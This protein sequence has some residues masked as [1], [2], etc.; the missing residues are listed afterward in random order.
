MRH[1][2]KNKKFNRTR[3]QRKAL[4]NGL[5]ANLILNE[6]IKT[7]ETKAKSLRPFV[8]KLITK[9][10]FAKDLE[11][12]ENPKNDVAAIRNLT[13][14][15]PQKAHSKLINEVA[16]RYRQRN[17]GYTRIIKL[18]PRKTDGAEIAIIELVK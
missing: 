5:A 13:K 1:H 3:D 17:G 14:V 18:G 7:T 6:R 15:L 12:N 9:G 16:P 11:N 4:L 2:N 8:E 10:R